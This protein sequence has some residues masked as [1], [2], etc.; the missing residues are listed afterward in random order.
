ME[1]TIILIIALAIDL[2]LGEFP[3]ALHPVVWMGHIIT[4]EL[5]LAP[6]T[7]RRVQFIYGTSITLLTIALFFAA[8]YFLMVYLHALNTILYILVAAVLLKSSFAIKELRAVA[9][10][11]KGLLQD[12]NLSQARRETRTLV[13]RD[14]TQLD[15][16][17]VV[18]ATVES[19]AENTADSVVAPLFYFLF[20][21]VPGALAYRVVNTFDARVG[22]HGEFEY[23]GKFAA[24]LDDVLNFIPSRLSGL[25]LVAAAYL[26]R[27]DGNSAWQVMQRD[28]ARTESPNAGWPMSA[29]AGALNVKLEKIGYY[30]LGG[31]GTPLSVNVIP[32]GIRLVD[33]A[34]L[35]WATFCIAMEVILFAI[36][37]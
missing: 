36:A 4:L 27:Q 5:K 32:R 3:G 34:V 7:G 19:I 31:G 35:I 14:T 20:L 37:T 29:M 15:E 2:T 28:H 1:T 18:S 25:L 30:A 8:S 12:T 21:G 22:Y 26:Y 10:R 9:I 17:H 23:L 11:I 16:A 6:G 13:K 24:R 33:I